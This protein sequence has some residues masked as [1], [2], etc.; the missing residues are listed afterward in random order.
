[1]KTKITIEFEGEMPKGMLKVLMLELKSVCGQNQEGYGWGC[2]E[3]TMS[4]N[5]PDIEN[6][7]NSI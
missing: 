4:T 6:E 7:T 3:Y 5:C 1:M 2:G